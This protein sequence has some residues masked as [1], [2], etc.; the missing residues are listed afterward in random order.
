[1]LTQTRKAAPTPVMR[2]GLSGVK[3]TVWRKT[4]DAAPPSEI[5]SVAAAVEAP[6][7]D[8]ITSGPK[9]LRCDLPSIGPVVR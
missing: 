3:V 2:P 9:T 4:E 5:A 7:R 8:T 6:H 1:M